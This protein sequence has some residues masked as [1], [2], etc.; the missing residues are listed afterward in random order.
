MSLPV[1]IQPYVERVGGPKRALILAVGLGAAILIF[2]LARWASAPTWVP[3]FANV[4]LESVSEMTDKL[5]QANIPF[6]LENGGAQVLVA[7][8][9]LA[10]ARVTL[11][12]AGLPQAGRPGL[13]L[14]D[15]PSWGMTDFTQRINYRR[16]LEGELERTMGEMRG[17]ASA[18]V[19]LVMH[20]A[21]AYGAADR[22][23]E[24]S[25]V[26]TLRSGERPSGDVVKGIAHL[27]GSSVEGLS[28]E[29]VTIVDDAGRL[30]SQADE[31]ES[32]D[33]LSSRQ[34]EQQREI[35]NYLRAKAEQ[36]IAPVV[37]AATAKVQVAA[38]LNFDRVERTS[39]TLDPDGQVVAQE[40]KAEIVPGAQ[41]G[42]A[43]SNTATTYENTKT[44]E[45]YAGAVGTLE[46]LSVAVLVGDVPPANG[47]GAG[48]PRTPESLRQIE[49][50]VRGAVGADS[51]RGDIVTVVSMPTTIPLAAP[52]PVEKP[53]AVELLKENS[54]PLTGIAGALMAFI[55]AFL[56][57]RALRPQAVPALAGGIA[58]LPPGAAETAA[59]L[60]ARAANQSHRAPLEVEPPEPLFI[61]SDPVRSRA[62]LTV[63]QKPEVAA[64]VL[65]AWLRES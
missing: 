1:P 14:F 44:T 43:S 35:E 24:A 31:P 62:A 28:S 58:A 42:A 19:H 53:G 48:T 38:S 41:G 49:A 61:A 52:A 63:D 3:A 34:L 33:G 51:A 46:R 39:S 57:I 55:I 60:A 37:G 8:T 6:R 59:A 29:R 5:T 25:V 23:T 21:E 27:V 30:L 50:L 7:A 54:R 32:A 18:K 45:R 2:G 47:K 17:I 36:L 26:L 4:P 40:Q 10:K 56:A 13:E 9:D 64:K 22:P 12:R 16:A 15:Q 11:A 65:R 20:E